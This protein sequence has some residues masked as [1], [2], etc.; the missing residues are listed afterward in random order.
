[1]PENGRFFENVKVQPPE[2]LPP[3]RSD[4]VAPRVWDEDDLKECLLQRRDCFRL[5]LRTMEEAAVAAKALAQMYPRPEMSEMGI[6]ELLANAIE[7]GNLGISGEEK[8]AF[9]AT[10]DLQ[11]E[12]ARRLCLPGFREKLVLL[13]FAKLEKHIVLA[14]TDEGEGFDHEQFAEGIAK[15]N[16]PNGRGI[17]IARDMVFDRLTYRGCGNEVEAVVDL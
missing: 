13:R 11:D 6:W 2:L 16:C 1:M 14:I 7:H 10:G 3:F 17:A 9:I 15:P 8:T 12:I 4:I 5:Q